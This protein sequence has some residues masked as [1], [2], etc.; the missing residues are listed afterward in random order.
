[1]PPAA[2][3]PRRGAATA[4]AGGG[5]SAASVVAKAAARII[6]G[7]SGAAVG[8]AAAARTM[9]GGSNAVAPPAQASGVLLRL[10]LEHARLHLDGAVVPRV[11]LVEAATAARPPKV[12]AVAAQ[13][14]ANGV[15]AVTT[16]VASALHTRRAG[17]FRYEAVGCY[18]GGGSRGRRS[19]GCRS[20][21]LFQSYFK[22]IS[23]AY[24]EREREVGGF[25][26]C[27]GGFRAASGQPQGSFGRLQA[28]LPEGVP[29]GLEK[30]TVGWYAHIVSVWLL[31]VRQ[32][33]RPCCVNWASHGFNASETWLAGARYQKLAVRGMT[34]RAVQSK[35]RPMVD[36][37][38]FWKCVPCQRR[39]K[40][41]SHTQTPPPAHP[42]THSI[43]HRATAP[44]S[45]RRR[46]SRTRRRTRCTRCQR[47][48][49]AATMP[50]T[51]CSC[52]G[53]AAQDRWGGD[54][55]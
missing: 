15:R 20:C 19:G 44:V 6:G 21:N 9:G 23:I 29:P 45:E 43:A 22:P 18:L 49:P 12:V 1:M 8:A 47:A 38:M 31:L 25:R 37:R 35:Q 54:R 52:C 10:E 46:R 41:N 28:Q 34:Q 13:I 48:A 24:L 14:K 50:A 26:G 42:R 17:P 55:G 2:R 5:S 30:V 16:G 40:A 53:E 4:R 11:Q 33:F 36:Q 32:E 7:S 27:R 3:I 51:K 39:T